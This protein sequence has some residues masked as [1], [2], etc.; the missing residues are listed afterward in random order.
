MIF[1]GLFVKL[2]VMFQH[3]NFEN[4]EKKDILRVSITLSDI[5]R[6][7]PDI[8]GQNDYIY[9]GR[10]RIRVQFINYGSTF[11]YLTGL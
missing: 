8:S 2:L 7:I 3:F 11:P 4:S 9:I 5:Q 6:E 1:F 10:F